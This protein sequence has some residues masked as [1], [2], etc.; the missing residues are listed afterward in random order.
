M[1]K[2]IVEL[3]LSRE[4]MI[5]YYQGT[6]QQIQAISLDGQSIFFPAELMR[7]FVTSTGVSG[8]FAIYYNYTGKFETIVKLP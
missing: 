8:K 5:L 7:Q 6:A 2:V 4:Q 3:N 1:P